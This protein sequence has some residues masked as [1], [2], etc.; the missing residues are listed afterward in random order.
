MLLLRLRL[1]TEATV[2]IRV[3]AESTYASVIAAACST[4]LVADDGV[5]LSLN[6]QQP[7][8]LEPGEPIGR[9]ARHGDLIYVMG[10]HRQRCSTGADAG[11]CS[12][13]AE[14]ERTASPVIEDDEGVEPALQ[15]ALLRSFEG[16]PAAM[17]R[18]IE[19][20]AAS[21]DDSP[22]SITGSYVFVGDNVS[23]L[24]SMLGSEDDEQDRASE[25]SDDARV[26]S[27]VGS[28]VLVESR[29]D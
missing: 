25:Q 20:D 10:A 11:S 29:G 13:S 2:K 6:K 17:R 27:L 9:L 3:P 21:M 23:G 7:L 28:V 1:P 24:S 4:A 15:L 5:W 8:G 18:Q 19:S 22:E 12:K 14:A 16:T 26:G